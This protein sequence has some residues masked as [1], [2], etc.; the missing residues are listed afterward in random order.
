MESAFP[1]LTQINSPQDLKRLNLSDLPLLADE[2][3]A[4]LI[5]HISKFGGHFSANL[6]VVEL[7][8]ALHYVLDTPT[9]KLVWDVGH[10]AYTHKIL[11]GRRAVF[12][13]NRTQGGISGFPKMA[14]SE[15][16]AFGTGHSSTSISAILGMAMAAKA[17]KNEQRQ[18]VAVIGDGALTGGMAFEALN[19]AGSLDTNI[20]VILNDNSIS[21]DPATGA[22]KHYFTSLDNSGN[23]FFE[24]L[25][26]KYFGPI[27]GHDTQLLVNKLRQLIS[28]KGP[29]LLHLKTTKGKG[30][31]PAEKE[32]TFW[33][34]PGIFDKVSG[35]IAKKKGN[36]SGGPK[37]Q[38]VFGKTLLRLAQQNSKIIGITP[39]MLS[40]CSM[41]IMKKAIPDRVFD[42]GIAE[43]HAVTF[44]AG[45][46]ADGMVP[47]CNLYSTF[48]QRA[49][50]QIIHDVC[51]QN[52]PVRF[53]LDR[54]GIVG[55]DGPTHHGVFDIAFLRCLPNM[56]LCSPMNEEE[57][58]NLMY[59]AS[60]YHQ[61]PICI[62]YPRG[63][64]QEP[65]WNAD[66][67]PIEIGKGRM[68]RKGK[69]IAILSMGPLG[70]MANQVCDQ[71]AKQGI[72]VSHAD[73]RF[74]KPLDK[75]LILQLAD[76]HATIITLEDGCVSGGFGS[77]VLEFVSEQAL[78]LKVVRLGVPDRFIEQGTPEELYISMGLDEN[79]LVKRI[80]EFWV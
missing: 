70:V 21:I 62:R 74:V 79:S 35:E 41:D 3:R 33:H 64:G 30:F 50:D 2:L 17:C 24:S 40:G 78:Q 56:V 68:L 28:I 5:D 61:G 67:Q 51:V 48:S 37:F 69:K 71:L 59:T 77:A 23:T 49:Y 29:K 72:Q 16:D 46:A 42:V 15:Y 65:D 31:A 38:D 60:N 63:N 7:A 34:A 80:K 9:D 19:H 14:E 32:Q 20:L 6:G 22:L 10:Q 11:T 47:F 66:F 13:S 45:L 43:Q 8:I 54:A 12:Q 57:L 25:N 27:D 1:L 52:L 39:A 36:E 44:A 53:C 76:E 26:F 73:M 55:A 58:Q 75:E 18:H 4:F